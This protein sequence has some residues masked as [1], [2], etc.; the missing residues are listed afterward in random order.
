MTYLFW[1]PDGTTS[2]VVLSFDALLTERQMHKAS[3]TQHPVERGFDA[4]DNIRAEPISLDFTW[5]TS[6]TPLYNQDLIQAEDSFFPRAGLQPETLEISNP[7][8]NTFT[9]VPAQAGQVV[10]PGAFTGLSVLPVVATTPAEPFR[11][12]VQRFPESFNRP[13]DV[14]TALIRLRDTGQLLDVATK[15]RL[16]TGFVLESLEYR[17]DAS[18]VDPTFSGVFR[19]IRVVDSDTAVVPEQAV[20]PRGQKKKNK[21]SKK[22]STEASQE[23]QRRSLLSQVVD[24]ASGLLGGSGADS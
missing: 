7:R 3:V 5:A 16:Y 22:A 8:R 21:G 15:S 17:R 19:Q 4:T 20:E 6:S 14:H 10:V 1:I 9:T 11:A 24:S 23:V 13:F 18:S 2:P 12:S